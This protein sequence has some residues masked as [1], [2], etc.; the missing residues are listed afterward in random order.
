MKGTI[1]DFLKLATE[2][3][4]LAKELVELARRND[5]EFTPPDEVSDE[6]LD[7]VA[8]GATGEQTFEPMTLAKQFDIASL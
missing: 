1:L 7:G 2:K 8:G 5:F 6:A 3:P 4:E